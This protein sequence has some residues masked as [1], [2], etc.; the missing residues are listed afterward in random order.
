MRCARNVGRENSLAQRPPPQRRHVPAVLIILAV[1]VL[2]VLHLWVVLATLA[3]PE[4]MGARA[5]DASLENTKI[6]LERRYAP[7]VPRLQFRPPIARHLLPVFATLATP[8]PPGAHAPH[9]KP[10]NTKRQL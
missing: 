2:H 8:G 3:I 10:A 7:L 1:R 9:V 4:P 5:P 6:I